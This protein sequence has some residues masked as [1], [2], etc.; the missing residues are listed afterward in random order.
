M[1]GNGFHDAE[2][3]VD[4]D[5]DDDHERVRSRKL[6]ESSG[7]ADSDL[8]DYKVIYLP[9]RLNILILLFIISFNYLS[10][11]VLFIP[12]EFQGLNNRFA[13]FQYFC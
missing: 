12:I 3:E 11:F 10:Y 7:Y 2:N 5:T 8:H 4:P 1:K 13:D 9:Y 6:S